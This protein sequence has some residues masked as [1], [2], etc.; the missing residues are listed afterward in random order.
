MGKVHAYKLAMPEFLVWTKP[1]RF[2]LIYLN[3]LACGRAIFSTVFRC[4]AMK[5]GMLRRGLFFCIKRSAALH[6]YY[7]SDQSVIITHI[8]SHMES[9]D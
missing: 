3:S 9:R 4:V 5:K 6:N 7:G 8:P 1:R 2:H